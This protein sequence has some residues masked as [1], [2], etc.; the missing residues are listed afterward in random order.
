MNGQ[1]VRDL[2]TDDEF[3]DLLSTAEE[4]AESDWE[5]GFVSDMRDKYGQYGRQM[6]I[7]DKQS[8]ILNKIASGEDR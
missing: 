6:F 1:M 7:T 5:N 2:Y 3:E 8:D 4:T